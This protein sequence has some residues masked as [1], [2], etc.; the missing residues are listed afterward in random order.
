MCMQLEEQLITPPISLMVISWMQ[1]VTVRP[2]SCVE[3][4]HDAL[5]GGGHER[6]G[7]WKGTN[8]F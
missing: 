3:L 5:T 1:M 2:A 7:A 8:L 6:C 4:V